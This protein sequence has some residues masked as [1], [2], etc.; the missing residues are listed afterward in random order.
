MD[1]SLTY[2]S[3]GEDNKRLYQLPLILAELFHHN[4]INV[5][6]LMACYLYQVMITLHFLNDVSSDDE[7]TQKSKI[8]S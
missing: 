6:Y 1:P 5:S 7:S 2:F 8:M 3:V 4:L